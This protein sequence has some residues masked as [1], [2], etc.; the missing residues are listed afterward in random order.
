MIRLAFFKGKYRLIP[1]EIVSPFK[2]RYGT[3]IMSSIGFLL[4]NCVRT[5]SRG[6][7]GHKGGEIYPK[8]LL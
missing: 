3:Q 2:I 1:F 5:G 8:A 7:G 6:F 4:Q